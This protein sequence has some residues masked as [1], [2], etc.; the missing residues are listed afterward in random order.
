[1]LQTTE[2]VGL[3]AKPRKEKA[4]AFEM[5]SGPS[6][7]GP[8]HMDCVLQEAATPSRQ[9]LS[10]AFSSLCSGLFLPH[11]FGLGTTAQLMKPSSTLFLRA[12][13]SLS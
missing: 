7:P 11:E 3:S 2:V 9:G 4:T 12:A 13:L 8:P 6:M 1:M 10:F 5:P